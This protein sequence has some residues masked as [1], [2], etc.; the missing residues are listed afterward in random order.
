MVK[1]INIVVNENET[2]NTQFPPQTEEEEFQ[3][4][5]EL[6]NRIVNRRR[7]NALNTND[8][9]DLQN[10]IKDFENNSKNFK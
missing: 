3:Y 8:I 7:R 9:H 6:N 10:F 2:S 4:E 5:I 1:T